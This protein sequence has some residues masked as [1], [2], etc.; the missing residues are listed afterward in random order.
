LW[1]MFSC[2]IIAALIYLPHLPINFNFNTVK[3]ARYLVIILLFSSSLI[4]GILYL[5]SLSQKW[6]IIII[7]L[8]TISA[9]L[10]VVCSTT[11]PKLGL[12]SS[13]PLAVK[14]NELSHANDI[15]V[16]YYNYYYDA[17]VYIQKPLFIVEQWSDFRNRNDDNWRAMFVLTSEFKG[18]QKQWLITEKQ[19][20]KFWR[21]K[22]VFI[23]A[24]KNFIPQLK[25]LL[26][27][28]LHYLGFYQK[29]VL[30]SN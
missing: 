2:C 17:S 16:A 12:K 21:S 24:N 29:N 4:L 28:N 22:K 25:F 26:G 8:I 14:I 13:K 20:K 19:L 3:S 11:I 27:N 10:L 15:V 6:N 30:I 18:S 5:K 23:I 7:I 1:I 9:L